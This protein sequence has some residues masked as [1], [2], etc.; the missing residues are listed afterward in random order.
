MRF[1]DLVERDAQHRATRAALRCALG[2]HGTALAFEGAAGAGK[3]SLLRAVAAES[4][5]CGARVLL[6]RGSELEQSLEFGVVGQLFAPVLVGAAELERRRLLGG[7]A[8]DAG[9]AVGLPSGAPAPPIAALHGLYWLC[10]KLCRQAPVLLA[11]DDAHWSDDASLRFL[12]HLTHRLAGLGLLLVVTAGGDERA[13]SRELVDGLLHN[14]AVRLHAIG[15]LTAAGTAA[16]LRHRLGAQS[17]DALCHA[18]HL[19][20]GG[21]PYLVGELA[22]ALCEDGIDP[23]TADGA[24]IEQI[25]PRTVARSVLVRLSR[26]G[27]DAVE[28]AR[29]IAIFP[30][31]AALRQASALAGLGE[32]AAARAA[33]RLADADLLAPGHPVRFR[34]PLARLA[35]C[36]DL[37]AAHRALLHRRAALLLRAE[38]ADATVIAVHLLRAEP[39]TA[40]GAFADLVAAA[41]AALLAGEPEA[42]LP[43]LER[44]LQE[45]RCASAQAPAR[46]MRA[47][48]RALAG[49][50]LALDELRAAVAGTAAFDAGILRDLAR[51]LAQDSRPAAAVAALDEAIAA[52]A[53]RDEDLRARCDGDRAWLLWRQD[54]TIDRFAVGLRAERSAGPLD[55]ALAASEAWRFEN[56]ARAAAL[57]RRALRGGRLAAEGADGIVPLSFAALALALADEPREALAA[58]DA[59]LDAQRAAGI[60][61]RLSFGHLASA[62]IRLYAGD[63]GGAERGLDRATA[64]SRGDGEPGLAIASL[65]AAVAL[66]RGGPAAARDLLAGLQPTPTWAGLQLLAVRGHV[67]LAAGHPDAALDDLTSALGAARARTS[68]HPL[69]PIAWRGD[70]ALAAA[71]TGD[72]DRARR[73][74]AADL[75]QARRFGASGALGYAQR[76]AGLVAGG[77]EGLAL[78]SAAA[79]TLAAS[80]AQLL[81]AE[82]LTD[83]GAALRRANQ[84]VAAR[85]PLRLALD[86]A[87]RCGSERLRRRAMEEQRASGGRPRRRFVTG[88]ESLTPSERRVARLAAS[89]LTN[90][91]ISQQLYVTLKT[92]EMHVGNALGKLRITS[93]RQ[94]AEIAGLLEDEASAA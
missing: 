65:R 30:D 73:L 72:Q 21:N 34:H 28:L 76:I 29:A 83:L 70:A 59:A 9:P 94:L 11:V 64:C 12:V 67:A 31:G 62:S 90:R 82:T 18:C 41:R 43:V 84:R 93:R 8:R 55:H 45:P 39:G 81:Y 32:S 3:T 26:L 87:G 49:G 60:D 58:I 89:G 52:T 20:T 24:A 50:P 25:G 61:D 48:A 74:V 33:D 10:A 17:S 15:S 42:A 19:A 51:L 16:S 54:A 7:P 88:V 79:A 80:P 92:V 68:L 14:E 44:A 35:V 1:D 36:R 53:G 91:E 46:Y 13:S 86:L 77:E 69:Y 2:G 27:P 57:A 66:E 78:L 37:P 5:A 85:G 22:R 63:L 71:A 38:G 4:A 47:T 40:P 75:A 56:A 23:A 6:A